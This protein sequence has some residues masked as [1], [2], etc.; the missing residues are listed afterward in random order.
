[1]RTKPLPPDVIK[2]LSCDGSEGNGNIAYTMAH[3]CSMKQRDVMTRMHSKSLITG[4]SVSFLDGLQILGTDSYTQRPRS[5]FSN[6]ICE[7]CSWRFWFHVK[8]FRLPVSKFS[9]VKDQRT[10]PAWKTWKFLF[11]LY[12]SILR[13]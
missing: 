5:L 11:S 8:Q 13:I 7:V 9:I 10:L 2:R 1:M 6:K 4:E 3:L 12:I